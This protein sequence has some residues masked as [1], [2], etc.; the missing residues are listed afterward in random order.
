MTEDPSVEGIVSGPSMT[1]TQTHTHIGS[2]VVFVWMLLMLYLDYLRV[3]FQFIY[4]NF[5]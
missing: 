5:F 2:K 1:G 4:S 3:N